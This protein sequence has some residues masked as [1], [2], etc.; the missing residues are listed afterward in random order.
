MSLFASYANAEN[1]C[2]ENCSLTITFPDGGEIIAD[3]AIT[4]TF[5]DNGL[6]NTVSSNTAYLANE[7]LSLAVGESLVFES[8]GYFD[9]GS[10]GNIDYTDLTINTNGEITLTA[11]EG[12]QAIRIGNRA[13]FNVLGG[14]SLN[15]IDSS[16]ELVGTLELDELSSLYFQSP[17]V[18]DGVQI[19]SQSGVTLS[20]V[21]AE[22]LTIN[23]SNFN[24]VVSDISLAVVGSISV[25]G[26]SV[27][28]AGTIVLNTP[29]EGSGSFDFYLLFSLFLMITL[30]RQL[31]E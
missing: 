21:N 13:N 27:I 5:G 31:R 7:T 3:Q 4:I 18:P 30:V 12:S 11:N 19:T 24:V 25:N 28:H 16:L 20:T 2:D 10:G 22:V 29:E 1:L 23:S 15:I 9:L 14:A 8:N 26:T 6:V 17:E